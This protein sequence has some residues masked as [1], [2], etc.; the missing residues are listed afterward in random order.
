MLTRWISEALA[1][2]VV[3]SVGDGAITNEVLKKTKGHNLGLG[4]VAIAFGMAFFIAIAMFGHISASVRLC[5]ACSRIALHI[6]K[7]E[8]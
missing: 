7:H 5:D 2:V 6:E 1:M 8:P 3:I 4:F